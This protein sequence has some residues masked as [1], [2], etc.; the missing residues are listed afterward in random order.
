MAV[1]DIR[2]DEVGSEPADDYTYFYRIYRKG[3]NHH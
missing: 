3:N 1:Q 2:M